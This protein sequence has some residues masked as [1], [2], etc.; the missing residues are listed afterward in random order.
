MKKLVLL[1]AV[2]ALAFQSTSC[3]SKKTDDD[4]QVVENADVEKVE[5]E[6]STLLSDAEAASTDIGPVDDSLQAALGETSSEVASDPTLSVSGEVADAEA[7][8]PPVEDIAAAPTLDETTLS[9]TPVSDFAETETQVTPEIP[10]TEIAQNDPV[11]TETP[12]DE[13][14]ETPIV[15]TPTQEVASKPARRKAEKPVVVQSSSPVASNSLKK[16]AETSPYPHGEGWVNT[17]YIAR[18]GEK[19]KDISIAIFGTDKVK[20]LKKINASLPNTMKGSEK[21]YYVSPNRPTDSS[22]T[23]SY[24]EDNGMIPET[25]VAK[26]GDDLKSVARKLLGYKNGY[27]ELW[28]TNSVVSKTKLD[29]GESLRYWRPA[30][31][32][33]AVPQIQAPPSQEQIVAQNTGSAN[34]GAQVIEDPSQLPGGTPSNMAT[35]MNPPADLNAQNM[36][37]PPPGGDIPAPPPEQDLAQQ[38]MNGGSADIPPPPDQGAVGQVDAAALTPPP[39]PPPPADE[40]AAAEPAQKMAPN[41]EEEST[42]QAMSSDTTMMLGGVIVLC[43]LLAYALIRRNKRKKEAEMAMMTETSVGT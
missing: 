5:A 40:I 10:A 25:Y 13:I 12:V 32:A 6:E 15:E 8:A 18:P 41:M 19:L 20:E 2:V 35:D 34:A 38:N 21:I 43:G 16:I 9:E 1:L 23:I 31:V 7:A 11:V 17:V 24:Y 30:A 33:Q 4:L 37:P 29:E 27:K 36:N 22:K 39:P 14:T 42:D 28:T 26:K 3:K